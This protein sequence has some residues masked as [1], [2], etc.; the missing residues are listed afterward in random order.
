MEPLYTRAGE[1]PVYDEITIYLYVNKVGG[2]EIPAVIQNEELYLSITDVF[3]FLKIRNRVST[4]MDSVTGFFINPE[5]TFVI[6][7]LQHRI[8][9]KQQVIDLEPNDLIRTETSLYLKSEYFGKV[10]ELECK[11]NF[12][13]LSATIDT[14]LDIPVIREIRQELIRRNINQLKQE[15]K[16]DTTIRRSYPFMHVGTADWS[17]VVTRK[18]RETDTR[19][20]LTLG[21]IIAGGEA[22]ASLNYQNSQP[23]T[24]NRQYYLWRFVNNDHRFLRQIMVGKIASQATS[25][26]LAPVVGVQIT[27]TPT[28]FRRS[29]G[30]YTISDFT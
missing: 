18:S 27:N 19:F 9:Y 24:L 2:L 11:F 20:N 4:G 1:E 14:K 30:T 12:R 3:N 26:I 10:F 29:F 23:F 13:S 17:M 25:S 5:A 28:T 21:S 16:A 6:D 15:L 7:R 22:T 8:N